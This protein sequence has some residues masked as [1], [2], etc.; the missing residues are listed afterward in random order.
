[1]LFFLGTLYK[2]TKMTVVKRAIRYCAKCLPDILTELERVPDLANPGITNLHCPT[3]GYGVGPD[4]RELRIWIQQNE[5]KAKRLLV[6]AGKL[7][8]LLNLRLHQD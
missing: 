7:E 6:E 2:G 1:M 8:S 4:E 3:H 5:K